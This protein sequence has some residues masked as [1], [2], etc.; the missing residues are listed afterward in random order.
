MVDEFKPLIKNSKFIYIWVSQILSQ[1]TINIMNFLLLLRL[2]AITGSAI[3]ISLLWV[4]YALP[5]IL[6]GPIA[7]ASVDMVDRR[8]M[9]MITNFLQALTIFTYAFLHETR[10]FLLYGVAFLYSFLNQ[11]YVPAEAASIPGVVPKKHLAYANG[12]FFITQQGVLVVGF[13]I[14]GALNQF[15][16]FTNSLYLCALFL[17]LA[18]IS[19]SFLPKFEAL[20]GVPRNLEEAIVRFFTRISEGYH[21]IKGQRWILFPFLLLIA[22]QI[23]AAM[24]VV[25]IPVMAKELLKISANSVGTLLVVPAGLGAALGGFIVPKLLRG[26]LRKKSVIEYA[27]ILLGFITLALGFIVPELGTL[28]VAAGALSAFLIGL[29]IVGVVIPSQ[30][31]LQEATPGGMR[32]RVFG[33]FWFLVTVATILPVVFSATLIEI[34]GVRSLFLILGALAFFGLVFSKRYGQKIIEHGAI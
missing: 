29:G 25:N 1:L 32:G 33:N 13:G 4:A 9:L 7:A 3:A 22:L 15:L 14:A 28:R 16:G 24:V 21:F 23:S 19:V 18:F 26:G 2:F 17:F 31:F 27:F 30:T 11:F 12:L 20:E 10:F 5:A 34:L 8:K 6:I